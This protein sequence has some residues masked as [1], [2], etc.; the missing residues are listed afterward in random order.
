MTYQPG[1]PRETYVS[2][3]IESDGPVPGLY[4]MLALGA[5][6]FD[7]DTDQETH[8]WYATLHPLPSAMTDPDTDRWWAAQPAALAE[9]TA[10]RQQ[11]GPATQS[12]VK[13]VMSLPGR[14]VA[15]AWPA[16]VDFS[17]VCWYCHKFAGHSPL[18]FAA[19]DI[20]S[21]LNGLA[22]HPAYYGLPISVTK[23][24]TGHISDAGLRPHVAVDDALGQGRTFMALRRHVIRRALLADRQASVS[25]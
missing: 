23:K 12:F 8:R 18:G 19:L 25:G 7:G 22:G 6:A 15:V 14:P 21:Y 9:V 20:R 1:E 11:P 13:W 24:M 2:I 17:F 10:N 16:T 4:S 5:V 3:D